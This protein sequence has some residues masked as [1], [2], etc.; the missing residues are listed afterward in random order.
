LIDD[1][2]Y[3]AWRST[4]LSLVATPGGRQWWPLAHTLF[5]DDLV[6]EFEVALAQEPS[7]AVPITDLWPFYKP[8]G[9]P[10]AA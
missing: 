8:D 2:E 5:G 3:R 1:A 7:E 9:T 6:R 10:P 4:L